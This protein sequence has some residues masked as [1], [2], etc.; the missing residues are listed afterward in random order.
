MNSPSMRL[1]ALT[2]LINIASG[3]A[4]AALSQMLERRVTM[5]V[6]KLHILQRAQIAS[7]LQREVGTIGTALI[8]EFQNGMQGQ[9][10]LLLSQENATLLVRALLHLDREL[11]N[12]SIAEQSALSEV[13]NVVL[14]A[15]I[16]ILA[17]QAH[18]RV[19]S[20]LPRLLFNISAEEMAQLLTQPWGEDTIGMLFVSRFTIG[21]ISFQAKIILVTTL[22][23]ETLQRLLD[24]TGK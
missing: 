17:D 9:A 2:E 14:N 10:S 23:D 1:D 5:A 13:G 16:A 22:A 18:T 8:Q 21:E 11:E 12:L 3:R 19:H 20:Q 7:F 6:I 15:C 24:L 4:A